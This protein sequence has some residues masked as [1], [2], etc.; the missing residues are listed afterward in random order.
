MAEAGSL[1]DVRVLDKLITSLESR[2]FLLHNV[3][4]GGPVV[5]QTRWAMSYLRGPLTRQQVKVA[6]GRPQA[7]CARRHPPAGTAGE[8]APASTATA[9]SFGTAGRRTARQ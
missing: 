8:T 2:V 6:D 3:N 4:Q 1:S 5:F 9:T 7:G